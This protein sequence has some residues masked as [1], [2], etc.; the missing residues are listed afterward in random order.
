MVGAEYFRY[1]VTGSSEAATSAASYL[2]GMQRLH[3]ITGI[4]GLYARSLCGPLKDEPDCATARKTQVAGPCGVLPPTA[5]PPG[6]SRCGLQFRNSSDPSYEGWVWKSD[7]SSDESAGHFFAFSIA[8]QLAPTAEERAAAAKTL[9]QMV[10]YVID[11]GDLN[12]KDWTGAATTWGR[13]VEGRLPT[14]FAHTLIII[15]VD[16]YMLLIMM[17]ILSL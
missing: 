7:T 14:P 1:Q 12:L 16:I 8:A 5:C 4:A 13:L 6:C 11:E 9:A 3:N 2:R 17:L 15:I 10:T